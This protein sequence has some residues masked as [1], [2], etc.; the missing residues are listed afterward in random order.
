MK[1]KL[2]RFSEDARQPLRVHYNDAGADVYS[3]IR[4]VIHPHATVKIPLGFGLELPDGV[5]GVIFPRS[6]YASKGIVC[7]HPPI[8]SGYRGEIHAIVT[9][10][11]NDIFVI[12]KFDRIGQ[13]LVIPAIVCDFVEELET[14]ERG[15]N[16]FG[17]SGT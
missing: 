4:I 1:I 3:P 15:K 11:T 2:I 10:M 8:D 13:L 6:S 16:G 9:N 17:S 12:N 14:E 5:M 7:E